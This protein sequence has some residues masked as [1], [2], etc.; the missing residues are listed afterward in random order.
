MGVMAVQGG[1][2]WVSNPPDGC[3]EGGV[4]LRWLAGANLGHRTF[5]N[6]EA[7]DRTLDGGCSEGR[8][9]VTA[10]YRPLSNWLGMAQMFV[11]GPDW[12]D[13]TLNVQLTL[14]RFSKDG[15]AVQV[16][17]RKRVDGGDD[18]IALVLGV[19]QRP[20]R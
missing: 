14:V 19:W 9:E 12:D 2:F 13:H 20:Q 7:A 18:G 4:E 17:L 10:G 1:A 3:G 5:V 15:G 11:D 6:V 16:G 8:F